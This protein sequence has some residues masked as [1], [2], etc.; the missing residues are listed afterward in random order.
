MRNLLRNFIASDFGILEFF[1][2]PFSNIS[3][4]THNGSVRPAFMARQYA[5]M[6]PPELA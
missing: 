2:S 3:P 1:Y 6:I 4:R 5:V